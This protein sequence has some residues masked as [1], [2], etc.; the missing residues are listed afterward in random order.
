MAVSISVVVP[1]F[2]VAAGGFL[3]K[4]L[5]SLRSQ[6][7]TDWECIC[8]DDGSTDDSPLILAR[9]AA[10][11]RR[12]RVLTRSNG[13]A[14]VARN[15]GLDVATGEW[16]FFLDADDMIFPDTLS[17]LHG[18]ASRTG[19]D[20]AWG[21]H[22]R[23][24][25]G[26]DGGEKVIEGTA[27]R[28]M[29]KRKF[30]YGPPAERDMSLDNVPIMVWNKLYR[31]SLLVEH[32]IR[33][34]EDLVRGEDLVF[35]GN[36]M[37]HVS[38]VAVTGAVTYLYRNVPGSLFQDHSL[39]AR[40]QNV[41]AVCRFAADERRSDVDLSGYMACGWVFSWLRAAW[42]WARDDVQSH[43]LFAAD[44]RRIRLAFSKRMPISARIALSIAPYVF[45]VV[46]K[47]E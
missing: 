22:T 43:A 23:T 15:A 41:D 11:D 6:T 40:A 37:R 16:I 5:E 47:P 46:R 29:L 35:Q 28:R 38:R 27:L 9:F 36:V 14:S 24:G 18:L 13:G 25:K 32:G 20:V 44:C 42:S 4:S 12:F 26:G 33:L 30:G 17:T 31:R 21:R 34:E 8:V 39:K 45:S 1:V 10:E 19:A 7:Y 3:E 2:N